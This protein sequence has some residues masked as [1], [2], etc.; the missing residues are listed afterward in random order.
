MSDEHNW[1]L[2]NEEVDRA[3][4]SNSPYIIFLGIFLTYTVKY[5]SYEKLRKTRSEHLGKELMQRRKKSIYDSYTVLEA[6]T[7]RRRLTRA[8]S[9]CH[10]TMTTHN[11]QVLG[12][13]REFESSDR[14]EEEEG[15]GEGADKQDEVDREGEV[16]KE[17]KF[18]NN[19]ELEII[20]NLG[21]GE[22]ISFILSADSNADLGLVSDQSTVEPQALGFKLVVISTTLLW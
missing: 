7:I 19:S 13:D 21:D 16:E 18:Q 1:R 10:L 20:S 22:Q 15:E 5:N 14:K 4:V 6:I 11:S 8:G 17:N 9:E 12:R 3:T 2:Y